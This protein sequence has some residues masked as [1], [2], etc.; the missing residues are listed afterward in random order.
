MWWRRA[1]DERRTPPPPVASTFVGR[2]REL[3]QLG[4]LLGSAAKG[5]ATT[6]LVEGI[7][8]IGKEALLDE[9]RARAEQEL[10]EAKFIRVYCYEATGSQDPFG[11]LAEALQVLAQEQKR[12]LSHDA[13]SIIKEFGP[14]T[15]VEPV[16]YT[17]IAQKQEQWRSWSGIV[18]RCGDLA[19]LAG[20]IKQ[21][22]WAVDPEIPV[23]KMMPM[24]DLM[25]AT[26]AQRRFTTLLLTIVPSAATSIGGS[27]RSGSK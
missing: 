24:T 7:V 14:D 10:P 19:P 1:R 16:L 23:T 17:P 2:D 27:I 21:A 5:S 25:A 26:L 22:V 9:A 6:V 18:V 13:L 11:P 15:P 4:A 8:G 12:D 20:G 3:E